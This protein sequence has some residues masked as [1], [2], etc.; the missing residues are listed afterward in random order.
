M[1]P[2]QRKYQNY[3]QVLMI[4]YTLA[5]LSTSHMPLHYFKC[6]RK[7]DNTSVYYEH[8]HRLSVHCILTFS[9][10][11]IYSI[12]IVHFSVVGEMQFLYVLMHWAWQRVK[13]RDG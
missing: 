9:D 13:I 2:E 6:A 5:D 10:Q 1:D 3:I 11:L 12:L 4:G 7:A 8:C